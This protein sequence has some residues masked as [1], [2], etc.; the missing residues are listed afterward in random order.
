MVKKFFFNKKHGDNRNYFDYGRISLN[1]WFH[2]HAWKNQAAGVYLINIV[3]DSVTNK[4]VGYLTLAT[5][6]IKHTYEVD[7]Q[8]Q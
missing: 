8:L 2:R 1:N 4:I 6:E 5:T 7:Q 3:C